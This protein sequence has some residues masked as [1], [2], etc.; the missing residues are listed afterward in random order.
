MILPSEEKEETLDDKER[1]EAFWE[2]SVEKDAEKDGYEDDQNESFSK[3][4]T[5]WMPSYIGAFYLKKVSLVNLIKK[6][7]QLHIG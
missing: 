4:L 2:A 5:L 1:E 3:D 7:V 6:E